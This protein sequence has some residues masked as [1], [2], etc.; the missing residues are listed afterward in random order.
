MLVAERFRMLR[1]EHL[2]IPAERILRSTLLMGSPKLHV[3][4]VPDT[5][6]LHLRGSLI[7]TVFGTCRLVDRGARS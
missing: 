6:Q 2:E 4:S 7:V 5:V 1:E 3:I